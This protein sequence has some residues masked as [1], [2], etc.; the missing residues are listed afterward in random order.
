MKSSVHLLSLL[1]SVFLIL[2]TTAGFVFSGTS[3]AYNELF[4]LFSGDGGT[5]V[6]VFLL[7]P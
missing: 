3:T 1:V 6:R 7:L 4:E 2:E 5:T